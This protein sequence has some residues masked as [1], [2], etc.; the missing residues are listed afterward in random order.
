MIFTQPVAT[1]GPIHDLLRA[2]FMHI[3]KVMKVKM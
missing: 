1:N 2:K 3:I